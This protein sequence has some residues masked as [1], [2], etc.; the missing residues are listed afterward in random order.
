[1]TY[2]RPT[3]TS[4]RSV[5]LAAIASFLAGSPAAAQKGDTPSP[6]SAL[7]AGS[8]RGT[9]GRPV[10]EFATL[11]AAQAAAV[12]G[13][14]TIGQT[15]RILGYAER[16]DGGGFA[17]LVVAPGQRGAHPHANRLKIVGAL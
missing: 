17:A 10:P 8:E 11:E 14:L 12:S 3:S 2:F 13:G 9:L 6:T 5:M 7:P 16:G 4:R 1:M 15:V